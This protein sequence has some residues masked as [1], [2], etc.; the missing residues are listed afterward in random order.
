MAE[1][2]ARLLLQGL[3]EPRSMQAQESCNA[4]RSADTIVQF[5]TLTELLLQQGQ[6]TLHEH[7]GR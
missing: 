2:V 5:K 4:P 3:G 7:R 1:E 6:I